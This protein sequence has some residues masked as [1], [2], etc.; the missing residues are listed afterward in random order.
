MSKEHKNHQN[1][2]SYLKNRNIDEISS[3]EWDYIYKK[4]GF[5]LKY[6]DCGKVVKIIID[7]NKK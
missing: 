5:N 4:F 7:K 1:I 3:K 2:V 6:D